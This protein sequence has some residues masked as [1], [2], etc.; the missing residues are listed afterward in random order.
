MDLKSSFSKLFFYFILIITIFSKINSFEVLPIWKNNK[1]ISDLPEYL[2]NSEIFDYTINNET[3]EEIY[4]V[5]KDN[6]YYFYINGQQY[7]NPYKEEGKYFTSPLIKYKESYYF[8]LE[9]QLIQVKSSRNLEELITQTN[10]NY[11]GTNSFSI[12]CLYYPTDKMILVAFKTTRFVFLYN[13]KN[14]TWITPQTSNLWPDYYIEDI[15]IK[16]FNSE[17]YLGIFCKSEN[18]STLNV[19]NYTS[20]GTF[21][22]LS[23]LGYVD[24]NN[25]SENIFS[26]AFSNSKFYGYSFSYEPKKLNSYNFYYL[27]ID[28]RNILDSD[29]NQYLKMFKE[30]EIYEA[31]FIENTPILI[32]V[33][34]KQEKDTS[35]NFYLG[36]VDIENHIILYNLKIENYTKIFYDFGYLNK[37]KTFLKIF[38]ENKQIKICPFIYNPNENTCSLFLKENEF[39]VIDDSAELNENKIDND[40]SNKI[41]LYSYCLEKCP[42]GLVLINDECILCTTQAQIY[43]YGSEKCEFL[44]HLKNISH[45]SGKIVYDCDKSISK[46]KYFENNCY[47]NCSEIYGEPYNETDCVTCAFGGKIYSNDKCS[48]SCD[49]GKGIVNMELNG[50]NYSFCHSCLDIG[51]FYYNGTCYDECPLKNQFFDSEHICYF[52]REKYKDKIYYFNGKCVDR[53][54]VGYGVKEEDGNLI[55]F[56]CKE[57]KQFFLHNRT[58]QDKCEEYAFSNDDKICYFCNE[59]SNLYYQNGECVS[60]CI[61]PYGLVDYG[62]C[63]KCSE[64][65]DRNFFKDGICVSACGT[66]KTK[67][68]KCEPCP[69]GTKYFFEYD[70]YES[71]PNYTVIMEDKYCQYCDGKFHIDHCVDECPKGY[72][73]NKT[74]IIEKNIDIEICLTCDSFNNSWF[75][76]IECVQSCP[77]SKYASEGNYCRLCFCGFSN[78]NC[79]KN[80]DKCICDSKSNNLQ[81]EIFGDNCEFFTKIKNTTEKRLSIIPHPPI[82]S[83]KKA[84]FSFNL[85]EYYDDEKYSYSIRWKVFVND[86]EDTNIQHFATGVNE[87]IFIVNSDVFQPGKIHNEVSLEINITDKINLNDSINIKDSLNISIQSLNQGKDIFLD[88]S[89]GINRVM[90]NTFL[91]NA[92]NLKGIQEYKFYYRFLIK[93]EHNE[94]IPIKKKEDLD[95]LIDKQH[96]KLYFMLPMFK[97]FLFELSNIREEKYI[98][99]NVEKKNENTYMQYNLVNILNGAVPDTIYNDIENIFLIMK[100]LDLNKNND[101]NLSDKEYEQLF[102]F[103]KYK[104]ND[105]ANANGSYQSPESQKENSNETTIRYYINYYEPKTI[106]S[107]M[108]KLFLNQ[109]DKIPEKFFNETIN[110]LK[111]FFNILIENN[112]EEKLDNSN[113][114]SFFRTFDHFLEI[115]I[116]KQNSDDILNK[117]GILEVLNKLI[118]Y[119]VSEVYPGETIRLVGKKISLF[120]SRFGEYQNYLSFDQVND[121]SDKIKYDDYNSF[122]F[123]DYN[124][125]Q[126][127]CD[128]NDEDGNS[129]LCIKK[130]NY[131]E[132]KG[133][134]SNIKN[135]CLSLISINNNNDN[136]FQNENEGNTFQLNI[137]DSINTEDKCDNISVFYKIKF[138]FYYIPSSSKN[139]N[140]NNQKSF[141]E[142]LENNNIKRDY[143]N[144]ACIPKN[145]LYNKDKYCL[146]F[147]NYDTN[148]IECTCNVMDEITYVSNYDKAKFYKEIQTKGKFQKYNIYNKYG[149]YGIFGLL[150]FIL[151]PNFFYLIYEIKNDIKKAKYKLMSY[152]EKIKDN[153]LQVKI[154]NN[155]SVCSFSILA[156]IYKFPYLSPLRNCNLQ[157]PKYIKHFIVALAIAYGMG[158][159]LLFFLFYSPFE[160]KQ[161]IIDKRD[162]KN[163]NFEVIDIH[164]KL[165]YLNRSIVL[166]FLGMILSGVFI[167]IFGKILSFNNDEKKYWKHMKTFFSNYV[168]NKIKSE[169][170]LGSTWVKIKLRMIA[171]YNLCGSFILNKKLKKTRK[172]NKN[173]ENYLSTSQSKNSNDNDLLLPLSIDEEMTELRDKKKKSGKYRPP[174]NNNGKENIK[175][176]HFSVGAINDSRQNSINVNSIIKIEHIDNFQLYSKKIK[177]NKSIEKNKKFERIKNK[178]ICK[179]TV[180]DSFD[181]EIDIGSRS[182]SFENNNYYKNLE[183]EYENN[184]S[185]ICIEEYIVNESIIKKQTKTGKSSTVSISTTQNPEGYWKI[186]I[187]SFI[188]VILLLILVIVMLKYIKKL[189]NDFGNFIIGV[190][191]TSSILIY[192]L[193]YPILYYIKIF[194]GSFL[195]FKCYHLKN[196]LLGKI[197]FWLFV[198]KTMIYVFKVRNYITKYKKEL[199]Y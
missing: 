27:N 134:V 128:D 136:Y 17:F 140:N 116:S 107:L 100:Y 70:C 171:Y 182:C 18:K 180:K 54:E 11:I 84:K 192:L 29:G 67:G 119:L 169:V 93:D 42:V 153:Y 130:E 88:S 173:F 30:A 55:C 33:I 83:S 59:T 96:Q 40:C 1:N 43:L 186:I 36:A 142:N 3:N 166:S 181:D 68:D 50:T 71:C 103:I 149:L 4:S 185:F 60:K 190:W 194:I 9:K 48:N 52:C 44:D 148:I 74:K 76:G 80:S 111:E 125:N 66:Y 138:P 179:K 23:Y 199:G 20:F 144:I 167:L 47:T 7:S 35:F 26:Y 141:I 5:Y 175:N 89:E 108:N 157:M 85:K 95:P 151:I 123:Y 57:N 121:I 114:L 124:I 86:I 45:I 193:V 97:S 139:N 2:L 178:Y 152:S 132:F 126:E 106:F 38:K 91:L 73:V 118:K 198:D 129:L 25:Y 184:I 69:E 156:F 135:Y 154:L 158:I 72:V 81:G 61:Y 78:S 168:N 176:D 21:S 22:G 150:A 159:S 165:K 162:I 6:G 13:L 63:K 10:I 160:E 143:A 183:I 110:I 99:T 14:S 120:L 65:Q 155:T 137:I 177:V 191:L 104:L 31:F 64:I 12:K 187:T 41:I 115:Y 79:S 56:N 15:N 188:L 82:V 101:L 196:R 92:D 19:F 58:C 133:N 164:I 75:N 51:K 174:S 37:N 163:K 117:N 46:T 90:D 62:I 102:S 172:V 109:K 77:E 189:L 113:I 112:N 131:K 34:R 32:Y 49:I 146:T 127:E 170:L 122:T 28:G 105:V 147:F 53:C 39:F 145:N 161:E 24:N 98:A 87:R 195:L 16:Y 94:I 197:F 8:C